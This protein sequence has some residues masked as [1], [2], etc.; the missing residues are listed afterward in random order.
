MAI[1]G[2][3]PAGDEHPTLALIHLDRLTYNL[4][5]LDELSAEGASGTGVHGGASAVK[6]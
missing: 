2:N 1:K 4:R 3:P 5:L 6:I